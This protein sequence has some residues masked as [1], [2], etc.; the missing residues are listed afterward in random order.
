[1]RVFEAPLVVDASG[2]NSRLSLSRGDRIAGKKGT[3]LY[4]L[5]ANLENVELSPETVELYFFHSGYG[6]LSM[7]ERGLANLC[8][9]TTEN[10]IKNAAGS[11]AQVLQ[12]TVMRNPAARQRLAK[13]R[14][15]GKWLSAGPLFFGRRQLFH[16]GIIAVGDAAGMIDPFT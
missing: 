4:A 14:V 10:S 7:V 9:L 3:R 13:A 2:R 15:V 8:F 1:T 6:G 5:K 12:Q 16:Q 11:P